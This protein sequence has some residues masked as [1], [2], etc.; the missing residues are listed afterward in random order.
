[1][2][3]PSPVQMQG[4][5]FQSSS[6]RDSAA[7]TMTSLPGAPGPDRK[8]PSSV[9]EGELRSQQQD[10]AEAEDSSDPPSIPKRGDGAV[11]PP[12]KLLLPPETSHTRT[13]IFQR[14]G[15]TS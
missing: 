11:L 14:S 6:N 3:P 10:T 8:C 2:P 7:K 4:D 12:G 5:L 15:L 13:S 1:M 9:P